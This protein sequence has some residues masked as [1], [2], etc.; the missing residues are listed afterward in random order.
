MYVV[1]I[2]THTHG[3]NIYAINL[4]AQFGSMTM[5][6]TM[7]Q[8]EKE[9]QQTSS[10]TSHYDDQPPK[11]SLPFVLSFTN[12]TYTVDLRRE[13]TFPSLLSLTKKR[14]GV[15]S[16]DREPV[17]AGDDHSHF[18]ITKTKTILKEISGEARDGEILALLGASGSGKTTLIDA[19]ANRI[20]K[21]S[22]KGTVTLNGEFISDQLRLFKLITA[23]VMQDDLLFPMLTVEETLMF[24]AEFRLPRNLPLSRKKNRVQAL[25]EQLGLRSVANTV[26]GDEGHRGVSGGERRR[27]SIG[28]DIIHDPIL[29][30]LDEP[31]SGLDSSSALIV[32]KV[33]Q[34]IACSGSIV[35]MSI[36]QPSFRILSLFDRLLFLSHGQIIYS[37]SPKALQPFFYE[38]GH[39]IPENANQIEFVLDLICELEESSP[40]G[41]KSLVDFNKT[42][43]NKEENQR[44]KSPSSSL[45]EAIRVAISKGKLMI[46]GSSIPTFAN[47]F[48]VEIIVLSKRSTI[49]SRRMPQR[50]GVRLI[51]V[52]ITGF[53][54][55]TIYWQLDH[56]SKGIR[57][58]LGFFAYAISTTYFA[59]AH[60]LP[61]LV[62]ERQ[63]FTR[64]TAYNAYRRSS[65]VLSHLLLVLPSLLALSIAFSLVTFWPVG[66]QGGVAGFS[67][68]CLIIFGSF[69]AGNSFVT[70]I[71]GVVP[72]ILL[73]YT[74]TVP[75]LAYFLLFSGFFI[76]RDRI[77]PY[78]LWFH[79]I[80]LVKYPYEGVMR[81][82][83]GVKPTECFVRGEQMFDN[84]PFGA[85]P[86]DMKAKMLENLSSVAVGINVTSTTC[87]TNGLDILK[88]QGVSDLSKWNCLWVVV[89]WGFFFRFLFYLSLLFGNKNKRK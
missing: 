75:I 16:A 46:Y 69:W 58:R 39:P 9:L 55:A 53:L 72:N 14:H 59:G 80:S 84:T 10:Y 87:L 83:F 79:Y 65:Y 7:E 4:A 36:H 28:V 54:L 47:P 17:L 38:F 81:N 57:E 33:L 88:L 40:D 11:P 1:Y 86:A 13:L 19:L 68:Y 70:F 66:L 37:G 45:E 6:I 41:A 64:E 26:I 52:L 51:M 50:F 5:E 32:V 49:N 77:P 44:N 29:L 63:I 34:K 61:I 24:A 12:L 48:W 60:S 15:P 21:G 67:F 30:F 82:E 23:Y 78:W 31:T 27:V 8:P 76:N 43:Q 85:L 22:L 42:W 89:A 73:G 3:Y 56:T 20:A 71:A 2:D 62:Q 25:I 18:F 35:V 74:I